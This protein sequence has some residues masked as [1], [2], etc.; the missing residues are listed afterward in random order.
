MKIHATIGQHQRGIDAALTLFK[1]RRNTHFQDSNMIT[2]ISKIK[3][4]YLPVTSRIKIIAIR[5]CSKYL[6][7]YKNNIFI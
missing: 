4:A 6:Y 3:L 7:A 5:T 1:R 2:L